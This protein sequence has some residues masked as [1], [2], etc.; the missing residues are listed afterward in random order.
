MQ[1]HSF[2][3]RGPAVAGRRGFTLIELLVVIAIIAVLIALL[4]PAVQ[5]ARE[6]ARR[7]QCQNNL[8]QL[9]LAVHNFHDTYGKL[10]ASGRPAAASTT[11]IGTFVQIL[12]FIEQSAMWDRYDQSVNWGHANNL[13]VTGLSLPA[14]L[15]PSAPGN[16]TLDHNPDGYGAGSPW[17]GIVA[18]GSYA[19][20]LGNDPALVSVAAAA[21]KTVIGSVSTVSTAS[22][23]TNGFLPKNAKIQFG[24]VTDGLSNTIAVWESAGRP[25]VYRRGT[26]VSSDL[27]QHRLNGGGWCRPASDV[28]FAGSNADGTVVPGLSLNR[29]NGLDV[30][31]ESYGPTGYPSVGTEG[32]SQPFSFHTGGLHVLLGDG[33]V[34]FLSESTDIGV[35]AALVTRNGGTNEPIVSQF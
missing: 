1:T 31:P 3:V 17:V 15:C 11:R 23:P 29:T 16:E 12:P 35:T 18:N 32:S 25:F 2:H 21:G 5:Q 9:G 20:S 30:G 26:L 28:L 13:P 4:L 10:P 22:Q 14:F 33:S 8:K 34:R 24:D 6:A 19:S 7:T 27:T